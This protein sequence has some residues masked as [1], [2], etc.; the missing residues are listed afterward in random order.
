MSDKQLK[1]KFDMMEVGS[2]RPSVFDSFVD[3]SSDKKVPQPQQDYSQGDPWVKWGADN[4]YPLLL[5]TL[6]AESPSQTGIINGKCY[7]ITSGGYT[8]ILDNPNDPKQS[9]LIKAFEKNGPSE[10]TMPE[11]IYDNIKDGELYDGIAIRGVWNTDGTRPAFLEQMNFDEIR[12]DETGKRFWHSRDWSQGKQNKKRSGLREIPILDLNKRVGEFLFYVAKRPKQT[13]KNQHNIYPRPPYSGCIKALMTEVE[14]ENFDLYEILNGFKAGKLINF[15]NA[16]FESKEDEKKFANYIKEGTTDRDATNSVMVTFCEG[17]GNAAPQV[18]NL[19]GNNMPERYINLGKKTANTIIRGHS[20]VMPALFGIIVEGG[21]VAQT[22][23]ESG[24]EIFKKTYVTGRQKWYNDIYTW[25]ARNLYGIQGDFSF[26]PPPPLF[27]GAEQED[28]VGKAITSLSPLVANKVL[29]KMTD[30]EVR[31]LGKLPALPGGDELPL[32]GNITMRI[33]KR[34]ET[35]KHDKFCECAKESFLARDPVLKQFDLKKK[36]KHVYGKYRS[37]FII[38]SSTAIP[39]ECEKDWFE[40]SEKETIERATSEK[41]FFATFL[42]EF[43][44]NVLTLIDAG[45][46]AVSIKAA[47]TEATGKTVSLQ[48]VLNSYAR[49]AGKGMIKKNGDLSDIGK[50]Y[51]TSNEAPAENFEIRYSYELR[52]DAPKLIGESRSFCRELMKMDRLYTRQEISEIGAAVD[53][54]VFRYNGGW[55]HNP[56]TGQNTPFCRHNWVQ[57]LVLKKA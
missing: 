28:P 48:E 32:A 21:L 16:S 47:L 22:E 4:C 10:Y 8:F 25:I 34:E 40:V 1:F 3:W 17:G 56:K 42:T 5:N 41:M 30:N 37:E 52:L 35:H 44:K 20:I 53:R 18:I 57:H 33:D 24:F 54:D 23:L 12:V 26:N 36:R 15:P 38:V 31:A 45:E 51:L 13:E 43:E 9:E 14:H 29:E 7:Y 2:S 11:V 55:Y 50:K 46:D 19:D 6:Y 27:G 49:L 39:D